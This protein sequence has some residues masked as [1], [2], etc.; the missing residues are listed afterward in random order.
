MS[1]SI[2]KPKY[3]VIAITFLST[4]G[5]AHIVTLI[6]E[7]SW[8]VF[9]SFVIWIFVF[10][11]MLYRC[12]FKKIILDEHGVRYKDFRKC[13]EMAWDEVKIVAIGYI[14]MKAP[15]RPAWIYFAADGVYCPML[16]ARGVNDKFFM[17]HYRRKVEHAIRL[18]WK[19]D[20]HGLV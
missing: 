10:I 16:S 8:I 11:W 6:N 1:F 2:I 12:L 7:F 4:L 14:P 18:Y 13:Y 5:F 19:S 17:V 3:A 20:I 9:T 15:G